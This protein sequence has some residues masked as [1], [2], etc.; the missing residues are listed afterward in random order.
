MQDVD[1]SAYTP[2]LTWWGRTWRFVLMA[3]TSA[4]VWVQ[5]VS[6]EWAHHRWLFFLDITLGVASLV[7]TAFRRRWPLAVAVTTNVLALGSGLSAGPA[8]LTAVSIATRRVMGQV[9]LLGVIS[10]VAGQ[11]FDGLQPSLDQ[12][13]WWLTL[14]FAIVFTI[15]MLASGMYIGSRR[16]L[17]WSLRERARAAEQQQELR[18]TSARAAERERIAREMHDV[19]AHRISMVSMH[20]GAL[21]FRTDLPP[22]QVRETAALI[23]SKAHEALTDLRQVLGVLRDDEPG[24]SAALRDRP[25]PTLCDLPG[26]VDEAR[27]AG[28]DVDLC[29]DLDPALSPA[30]QVGRTVYRLVQEGLTNARKH[31]LGTRVRVSVAGSSDAGVDVWVRNPLRAGAAVRPGRR[32]P[33]AGLGLVGLRERTELVGG[34]LEV[35]DDVEGFALHGWLP[36]EG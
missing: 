24:V 6:D 18:V 36:W 20:A 29:F 9:V 23:Q 4:V 13:P 3:A 34:R 5:V 17:L 16:E 21:A 19:L 32:T 35:A 31:A 2:P 33:G 10:V 11:G 28:M 1:P 30:D 14:G 15:A 26:L 22:E 25:Q 12:E 27:T 7:L 8:M